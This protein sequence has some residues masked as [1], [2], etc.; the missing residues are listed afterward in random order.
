[1]GQYL[2]PDPTEVSDSS[3]DSVSSLNGK[4]LALPHYEPEL[5]KDRVIDLVSP[6]VM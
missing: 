1:M 6:Y 4:F 3:A 2:D 5:G